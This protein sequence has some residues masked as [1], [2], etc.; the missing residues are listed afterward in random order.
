M[1]TQ[2]CISVD[3]EFS[4]GGAFADADCE[5]VAEPMV[6]CDVNG[7]S[8]GLGFLLDCFRSHRIKATFFVEALHRSYFKHDPMGPIARKIHADGHDVELHAHPCWTV[9]DHEDWR[10][11]VK[12]DPRQDDFFGRSEESSL[13]LIQKGIDT[14]KDWDLPRPQT[15]RS[16]SLQHD[17]TLYRA[18]ARAGIPFSSN[19]GLAIFDSGDPTY[20]LYGG[21]HTRHGVV[22]C[23][24]MTFSDW[25]FAGRKHFK[26]LTI[27]GTSFAETRHLLEM[28][29]ASGVEQV[30]VL[31]HPFEFVQSRDIGR[32][33]ARTHFVNQARL[34]ALCRY[35]DRNGD[36]FA[37]CG[38]A[39]AAAQPP[40]SR[41]DNRLFEGS[42]WRSLPRMATQITYDKYGQFAL[43]RT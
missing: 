12:S 34:V 10:V 31:T 4:I 17:D 14:F 41:P 15:F 22:E 27:A 39:A 5:P 18:L 3:T 32:M 9:F 23:P 28:A 21:R 2:V 40:R 25:S 43:A 36:R 19:V 7:Q 8:E 24:V 13:R 30:V 38:L 20:S 1:R 42:L 26:S 11:R 16:G 29:Q 37:T 33:R 6:W 35:L